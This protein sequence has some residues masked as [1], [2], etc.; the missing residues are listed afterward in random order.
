M[1][2][3]QRRSRA[4]APVGL[5]TTSTSSRGRAR[6]AISAA[7]HPVGPPGSARLNSSTR[8][9]RA[10]YPRIVSAAMRVLV[11]GPLEPDSM[12]DNIVASLRDA[13]HDARGVSAWPGRGQLNF[14]GALRPHALDELE[15][16]P[17]TAARIHDR[18]L[19]AAEEHRPELTLVTDERLSPRLVAPLRAFGPVAVWFT[20]SLALLGRETWLAAGYDLVLTTDEPTARRFRDLRGVNAHLMPE[21]CNPAWHRPPAGAVPGTPG[22]R[23]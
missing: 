2:R 20:D 21:G 6:R 5:P 17:R 11:V 10:G 13:G 19:R 15:R 16:R 1:A 4:P 9:T 7:R 22:P 8:S 14:L 23:C 12:A 3:R 18:V